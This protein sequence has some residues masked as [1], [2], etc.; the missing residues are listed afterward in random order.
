MLS[1]SPV[2]GVENVPLLG[3]NS[4]RWEGPPSTLFSIAMTSEA[5]FFSIT[6]HWLLMRRSLKDMAFLMAE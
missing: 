1:H 4:A 3:T 6:P 5:P 2:L